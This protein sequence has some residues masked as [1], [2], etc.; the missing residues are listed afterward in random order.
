MEKLLKEDLK[1][2]NGGMQIRISKN[3]IDKPAEILSPL[4]INQETN[5]G[6]L[7]T[8]E[9]FNVGADFIKF[10]EIYNKAKI[11]QSSLLEFCINNPNVSIV[12][13]KR[14]NPFKK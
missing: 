12:F 6:F 13:L 1:K 5:E 11:E 4:F 14:K 8:Q 9:D 7:M 3:A 2:I 10:K